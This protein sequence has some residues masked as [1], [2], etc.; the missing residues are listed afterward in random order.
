[1]NR[2]IGGGSGSVETGNQPL[3]LTHES[4]GGEARPAHLPSS[5]SGVISFLFFLPFIP[6]CFVRRN[7][8]LI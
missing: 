6:I 3:E 8:S 4:L 1:M 5:D 7:R 2:Q